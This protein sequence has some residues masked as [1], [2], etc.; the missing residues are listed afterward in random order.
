MTRRNANVIASAKRITST[1]EAAEHVDTIVVP[2]M[3]S[4]SIHQL[5]DATLQ[6]TAETWSGACHPPHQTG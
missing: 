5:V 1:R 4:E 3:E 6:V 2:K